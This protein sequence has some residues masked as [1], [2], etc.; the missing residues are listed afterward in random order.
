MFAGVYT[1]QLQSVCSW[2]GGLTSL[3]TSGLPGVA[4]MT[5]CISSKAL[6]VA[7][8]QHYNTVNWL[9][10][11]GYGWGSDSICY[12]WLTKVFCFLYIFLIHLLWHPV[13][14]SSTQWSHHQKELWSCVMCCSG[15]CSS[16]M[17]FS[18]W[19]LTPDSLT[20]AS[21]VIS[22]TNPVLTLP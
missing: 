18:L 10:Y 20:I 11:K 5:F 15:L 16:R 7:W 2:E 6:G 13:S 21:V 4:R 19:W 14:P 9:W 22:V 8:S 1:Y 17:S 3:G 12:R